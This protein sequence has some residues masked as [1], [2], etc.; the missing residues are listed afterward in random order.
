MSSSMFLKII[1]KNLKGNILKF[2]FSKH[3]TF[4]NLENKKLQV[5][6]RKKMAYLS[7]LKAC[8]DTTQF[9]FALD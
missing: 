4:T 7:T 1:F 9:S 6:K 2:Y 3:H 8:Y 5:W